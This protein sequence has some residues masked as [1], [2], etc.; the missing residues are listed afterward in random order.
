[1]PASIRGAVCQR[2]GPG[3]GLSRG[4]RSRRPRTAGPGWNSAA[5][6]DEGRRRRRDVDA[7]DLERRGVDRVER[8][9][10]VVHDLER[11][12]H[13]VG[14]AWRRRR[15]GRSG[16]ARTT[17]RPGPADRPSP[18]R[19]PASSIGICPAMYTCR[20]P[21]ATMTW[22]SPGIST[23]PGGWIAVL[24][25]APWCGI[26][27]AQNIGQVVDIAPAAPADRVLRL[28]RSGAPGTARVDA[29]R[30]HP[31]LRADGS[32]SPR[33]DVLRSH[34]TTAGPPQCGAG[35]PVA[36]EPHR[37]RSVRSID[38]A[39]TAASGI[40]GCVAKARFLGLSA[41]RAALVTAASAARRFRTDPS[42]CRCSGTCE[43]P[44]T[45]TRPSGPSP[46]TRKPAGWT[47]CRPSPST[48]STR[49]RRRRSTSSPPAGTPRP[50]ACSTSCATSPSPR[51]SAT[52]SRPTGGAPT[53]PTTS[54]R[55]RPA[56]AFDF[57]AVTDDLLP[58]WNLD[59]G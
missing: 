39:A 37:G 56:A 55:P 4:R 3:V 2:R 31:D 32:W 10:A 12:P 9:R 59:L 22:V 33:R 21:E 43:E 58:S 50:T 54:C 30:A 48:P 16:G 42:R 40:T 41:G 57:N 51:P 14:R 28:A 25:M 5:T 23:M 49:P 47:T 35:A 13:D 38:P 36:L 44:R 19:T 53:I 6:P 45:P 11:H 24:V 1:M 52:T 34:V 26:A 17:R 7:E 29:A 8:L 20:E 15:R 18:T 27:A 46:P